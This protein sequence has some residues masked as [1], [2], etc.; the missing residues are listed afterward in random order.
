MERLEFLPGTL[1]ILI[2]R[3]LVFGPRHGYAIAQYI[4]ETSD[5]ALTV[6][7]GSLYPALQRMELQKLIT[8]KWE[9]SET[10]R[11][12]RFYRLTPA[13]RKRLEA[14]ISRWDDFVRAMSL[15]LQPAKGD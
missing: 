4:R 3:T 11:K 15:V 13:G 2:L 12:A 6:E 8:A 14:S 9:I 7:A 1:E 10:H 5:E